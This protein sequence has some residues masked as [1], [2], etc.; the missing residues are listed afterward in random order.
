[1]ITQTVEHDLHPTEHPYVVRASSIQRSRY[2][3]KE[4]QISISHIAK[5]YQAGERVDEI[6]QTYPYLKPSAVYDAISY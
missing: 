1:M 3:I 4:T 6:V 5:L 2:I